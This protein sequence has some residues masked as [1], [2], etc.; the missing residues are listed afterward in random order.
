MAAALGAA[1]ASAE[2]VT[3]SEAP[4]ETALGGAEAW[5]AWGFRSRRSFKVG[6]MT[7]AFTYRRG[8]KRMTGWP[9]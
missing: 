3:D 7:C 2:V 9:Y 1:A 6:R 8:T 5:A 4:S